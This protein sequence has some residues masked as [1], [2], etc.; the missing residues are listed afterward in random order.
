MQPVEIAYFAVSLFAAL[1]ALV[2]WKRRRDSNLARL[3]RGLRGYMAAKE[4][5]QLPVAGVAQRE[6]LIPV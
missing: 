4:A 6:N 2:S 1:V 5:V 3:N